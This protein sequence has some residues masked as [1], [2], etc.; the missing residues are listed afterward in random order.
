MEVWIGSRR[1]SFR[2]CLSGETRRDNSL[3]QTPSGQQDDSARRKYTPG[4]RTLPKEGRGGKR[5]SKRE[6]NVREGPVVSGER[7]PPDWTSRIYKTAAICVELSWRRTPH[8]LWPF[9]FSFFFFFEKSTLESLFSELYST[10]VALEAG[11]AMIHDILLLMPSESQHLSVG[12]DECDIDSL[13]YFT[14]ARA[15]GLI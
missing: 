6:R 1:T 10:L 11:A 5:C 8:Y 9:F 14:S 15:S 2:V 12:R 13:K 3:P 7:H 4:G